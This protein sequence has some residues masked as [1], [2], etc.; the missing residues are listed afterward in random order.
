MKVASWGVISEV[1]SD[2]DESLTC[3]GEVKDS[4]NITHSTTVILY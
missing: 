3:L 4:N 1:G 2:S